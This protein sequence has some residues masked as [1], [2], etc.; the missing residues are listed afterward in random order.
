MHMHMHMLMLKRMPR[1]ILLLLKNVIGFGRELNT[2]AMYIHKFQALNN[3]PMT[4]VLSEWEW[5][6]LWVRSSIVDRTV[7]C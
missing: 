6:T 1:H 7:E 4:C 5:V 3:D 2:I